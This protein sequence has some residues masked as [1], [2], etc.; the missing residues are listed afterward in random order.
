MY[1]AGV[2]ECVKS[3]VKQLESF[4]SCWSVQWPDRYRVTV[5]ASYTNNSELPNT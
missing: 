5:A 4:V 3:I 2:F 1:V